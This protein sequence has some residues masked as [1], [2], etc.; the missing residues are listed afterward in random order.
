MIFLEVTNWK[1]TRI[2]EY[3]LKFYFEDWPHN[4]KDG[5]TEFCQNGSTDCIDDIREDIDKK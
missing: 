3:S 5:I 4:V 1:Y 2:I